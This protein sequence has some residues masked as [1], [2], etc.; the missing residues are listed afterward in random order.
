MAK[1][2]DNEERGSEVQR[3][4]K[5][6]WYAR[7]AKTRTLAATLVLGLP[8]LTGL[9]S[10]AIAK[11]PDVRKAR[12]QALVAK[13]EG[14]LEKGFFEVVHG[15]RAAAIAPRTCRISGRISALRS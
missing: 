10:Y 8:A 11:Q 3:L 1:P 12:E 15:A 9:A 2:A 5:W 14:H 7:V 6:L 4:D 13:V